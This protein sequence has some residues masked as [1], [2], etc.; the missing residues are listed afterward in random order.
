MNGGAWS[1]AKKRS[2]YQ[3]WLVLEAV[4]AVVAEFELPVAV[5]VAVAPV[6]VVVDWE[7]D[8]VV[9][10]EDEQNSLNHDWMA[11]MPLGSAGNPATLP[12]Q[13]SLQTPRVE[14]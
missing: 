12:E 9:G 11:I 14:V 6:L 13:A 8:V 2:T 3:V 7:P 5:E 4:L 10:W 1:H